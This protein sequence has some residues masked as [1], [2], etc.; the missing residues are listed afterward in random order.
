MTR[1]KRLV[2]RCV[3][4][5][6]TDK[7]ACVDE[8]GVPCAWVPDD[9]LPGTVKGPLCSACLKR[10]LSSGSRHAVF[11]CTTAPVYSGLWD[12]GLNMRWR[13][14]RDAKIV[15]VWAVPEAGWTELNRHWDSI[16]LRCG[17]ARC[18]VLRL[19]RRIGAERLS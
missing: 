1:Q 3:D 14:V 17:M 2:A 5:G 6:C 9:W 11:A 4:C 13:I 10:R 12:I 7:C 8:H 15:E 16:G 19:M 18:T